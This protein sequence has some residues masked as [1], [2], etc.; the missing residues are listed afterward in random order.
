MIENMV[1]LQENAL[2]GRKK[3][4][5]GDTGQMQFTTAIAIVQPPD[6]TS[7]PICLE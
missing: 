1:E 7:V 5:T 6:M 4:L 3:I 2:K